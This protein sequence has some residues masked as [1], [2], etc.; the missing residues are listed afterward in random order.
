MNDRARRFYMCAPEH[1]RVDYAINAWTRPRAE[2]D[3]RRAMEQWLA[4]REAYLEAGAEVCEVAPEAGVSELTFA[5]D[6]IFL[7]GQVAL[8]SRFRHAERMPEVLPMARRFRALGYDVREL[9]HGMHF[10]GNAEAILWNGRL[11]GGYGVRS[12]RTA[13]AH[14]SELLDVEV[15]PFELR[16]PYYHL[17]VCLCPLD[18]RSALYYPGGFSDESR[19]R[20]MRLVPKLYPVSEAEARALACNSVSVSDT[21]VMSTRAAPRVASLLRAQGRRVVELELSEFRKAGGG[22]KCLTL[23][24]YGAALPRRAVA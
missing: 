10:E 9:P 14:V 5:G 7:H 19:A 16:K 2:V 21:V 15:V 17:D 8:S 18:A 4:L 12:D 24:A 6:S 13:L 11:L 3:A 22:A 1:F 23:E 20:L